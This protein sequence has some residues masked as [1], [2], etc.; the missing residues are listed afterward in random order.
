[1]PRGTQRQR[2]MLQSKH[3]LAL[4]LSR[5]ARARSRDAL[6]CAAL[7]SLGCLGLLQNWRLRSLLRAV[8][9]GRERTPPDDIYLRLGR[10]DGLAR[11]R[12]CRLAR[13]PGRASRHRLQGLRP[14]RRLQHLRTGPRT[15]GRHVC[16]HAVSLDACLRE[17]R[18]RRGQLGLD[19]V[20][21]CQSTVP[22]RSRVPQHRQKKKRKSFRLSS[23][24]V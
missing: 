1:M 7:R 13:S 21:R 18:P 6:A 16:Y 4:L 20:A 10:G 15:Q 9:F 12:H 11:R 8:S 2:R 14:R 19:P 3:A 24:L 5:R 17:G 22:P 23:P